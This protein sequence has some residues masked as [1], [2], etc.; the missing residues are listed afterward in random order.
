[1]RSVTQRARPQALSGPSDACDAAARAPRSA[2]D[3]TW[4]RAMVTAPSKKPSTA[5]PVIAATATAVQ[6]VATP[7]SASGV[8]PARRLRIRAVAAVLDVRG[9]ALGRRVLA[10][11][12]PLV[13]G[14]CCGR[15]LWLSA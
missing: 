14:L 4:C 10:S 13:R 11:G 6:I 3:S 8:E 2:A 1:M 12:R 9:A 5:M 7:L 15:A